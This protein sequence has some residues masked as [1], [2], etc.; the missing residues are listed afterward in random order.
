MVCENYKHKQNKSTHSND[1]NNMASTRH[2][3]VGGNW[4]C[5]GTQDSVTKLVQGLNGVA[6]PSY[7]DVVIAP[8]ALHLHLVQSHLTHSSISLSAQDCGDHENG[9]FT[10]SHTAEMLKDSGVK[11]VI[12]GHS[13]RRSVFGDSNEVVASKGQRV[14]AQGLGL[15]ACIGE[16]L[17]ERESGNTMDVVLGQ[18][19]AFAS[20]I[21][22][23]GKVVVAYEP[24]WAIGTGKVASPADAQAVHDGI[25]KWLNDN[26]SAEVGAVS[27]RLP[28][29]V[30][31]S[32]MQRI[33]KDLLFFSSFSNISITSFI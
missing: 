19:K 1:K 29:T 11:W 18:L 16:K 26:V 15:I 17:E 31:P 4:K 5:N 14:L 2:F 22:D 8:T 24:V 23:W 13:E 7:V 12:V 27:L 28:S 6:I 20:R 33:Y 32:T 21:E 10:S 3:F 9:A 25:R 30:T